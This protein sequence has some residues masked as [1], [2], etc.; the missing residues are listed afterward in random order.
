MSEKVGA[1]TDPASHMCTVGI[2]TW[3]GGMVTLVGQL[4]ASGI[5]SWAG[6]MLAAVGQALAAAV[7]HLAAAVGHLA[8]AVGPMPGI[9]HMARIG[10]MEMAMHGDI[11]FEPSVLARN[12]EK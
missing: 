6:G 10:D 11:G 3:A 9:C 8:A 4:K 5:G 7:G 12:G 2:G 1:E